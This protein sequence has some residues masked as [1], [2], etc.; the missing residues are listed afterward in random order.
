MKF[1]VFTCMLPELSPAEALPALAVQ[2]YDAVCWRVAPVDPAR[3]S[4]APSFWGN[5]RCTLDLHAVEAEAAAVA[6]L[7]KA[8]GIPAASLMSYLYLAGLDLALVKPLANAA[9]ILGAGQL[10]I[11]APAYDGKSAYAGLLEA[12]RRDL[13]AALDLVDGACQVVVEIHMGTIA[14]SP[15]LA[16]RLVEGFDPKRVGLIYDPANMAV[17]GMEDHR[18]G[19]DL[20]GDYLAAVHVKNVGWFPEAA[21]GWG[22]R[23]LPIP[24][25][26]I[27][28]KKMMELLKEKKYGGLVSFEDFSALPAPE[29]LS[30]NLPYIKKFL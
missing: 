30:S 15:S 13:K 6:P 10:R 14:C 12:G 2:G 9:K 25:G 8:A 1:S 7:A 11:N 19:L 24:E 16:M 20:L 28:W 4:E 17:E 3:R 29:K 5:N 27:D 18:L 21:G 22:W 23:F 26:V